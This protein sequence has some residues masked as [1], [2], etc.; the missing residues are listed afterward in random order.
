MVFSVV[1]HQLENEIV[2]GVVGVV[3]VDMVDRDGL[4]I[5]VSTFVH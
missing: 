1:C 2:L 3:E 4:L 5:K